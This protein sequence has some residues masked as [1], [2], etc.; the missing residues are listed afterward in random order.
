MSCGRAWADRLDDD[1]ECPRQCCGVD[2]RD[3]LI[4]GRPYGCPQRTGRRF[5]TGVQPA[6]QVAVGNQLLT[7]LRAAAR[8]FRAERGLAGSVV[9]L[10]ER[11]DSACYLGAAS[12]SYPQPGDHTASGVANDVDRCSPGVLAYPLGHVCQMLRLLPQITV[13]ISDR[14]HHDSST[15]GRT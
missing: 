6:Q 15:A 12:V 14:F 13:T 5:V 4:A 10:A 1:V 9:L 7:S 11:E 2:R 8:E 3:H